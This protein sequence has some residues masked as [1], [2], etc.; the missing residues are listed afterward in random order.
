M[1]GKQFYST[2]FKFCEI[3][4]FIKKILPEKKKILLK[5]FN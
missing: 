4:K 1:D 2:F 5:K 3:N